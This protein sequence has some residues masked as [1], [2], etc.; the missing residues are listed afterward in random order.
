MSD[1][2][3]S[4][5]NPGL[6]SADESAH[7]RAIVD[8]RRRLETLERSGLESL[9]EL[10]DEIAKLELETVGL[11]AARDDGDAS[12]IGLGTTL[13][14]LRHWRVLCERNQL[15][16][17]AADCVELSTRA[18]RHAAAAWH[19]RV[20]AES[21]TA[22][23][24]ALFQHLLRTRQ[25]LLDIES[26][27]GAASRTERPVEELRNQLRERLKER[28]AEQ[29][30]T[31]A[32]SDEWASLIVDQSATILTAIDELDPERAVVQLELAIDAAQWHLQNVD[33]RR[34]RATSRIHAKLK[35]LRA[36][37]QER[38][39]NA[40]MESLF[41]RRFVGFTERV[42]LFLIVLVIVLMGIEWTVPLSEPTLF[43]FNIVDAGACCI[44]LLEFFTRLCL[45]SER[46]SWF[47]RHFLI[48]LVPSIPIGF[49]SAGLSQADV[50]RA[51]RLGRLLRLSR[52][53]RY[54]RILR[55]VMQA[56][57]V[58]GLMAR[59]IDRLVRG[60]SHILNCNVV[61]HPTPEES[62]H[63]LARMQRED[64][65]LQTL[66]QRVLHAWGTVLTEAEND[67]ERELVSAARLKV[68]SQTCDEKL[69]RFDDGAAVATG[70]R[71]IPAEALLNQMES[72]EPAM[73]E[74][75]LG[76]P[77]TLQLAKAVR[78][79]GAAPFKWLP[80]LR[81][82]V[83][84]NA[85][86]LDDVTAIAESARLSA[87][88]IRGFYDLWFWVA[89]LYGTVTPSQFLDRV[90][91]LLVKSSSR[92]AYRLALFG[93]FLLLIEL[94]FAVAELE[95]LAP[96][97]QFLKNFVGTTVMVVGGIC[98]VILS[99]GWWLQRVAR[100][101]TEF[102]EK[103]VLGQ[104]LLLTDSI[105]AERLDRDAALLFDRV[106]MPDWPR[107][108]MGEASQETLSRADDV[109]SAS[110]VQREP[111]TLDEADW[112]TN[113]VGELAELLRNSM[114]HVQSDLATT[115]FPFLD[116][117]TLMYRDW[118]DGAMF[119]SSDTRATT[120]LLGNTALRQL[121]LTS[122]RITKKH[123]K[124]I[125]VVD[126]ES[127]KS[128]FKGPYLWF[129]FIGQSIAHS[130]ACL[131]VEYN[132][133]A[134]PLH[135]LDHCSDEQKAAYASW[136]GTATTEETDIT[137]PD[138]EEASYVTTAFT[139]LHFLDPD[140]RRE[141]EVESRFGPAVL[142]R[143]KR[144]RALMIRRTFG[145]FPMH[146]RPRGERVVNLFALYEGWIAGG[147]VFLL[148]VFLLLEVF[149]LIGKLIAFVYRAAKEIRN[150]ERRA[151]RIDAAQADFSVALRK[152]NRIRGPVAAECARLRARLDPAWLGT[153]LPG[154]TGTLLQGSDAVTDL[155]FLQL[156]PSLER[157]V[158]AER[159]RAEDDMRLLDHALSEGL[160]AR[161]AEQRGLSPSAFTTRA[162]L[163]AA[164]IA[165]HADLHGVRSRLFARKLLQ[166][167][168]GTTEERPK[169]TDRLS[170]RFRLRSAFRRYWS[171]H[172]TDDVL[173]RRT[174]WRATLKNE[175][176]IQPALHA[177]AEHGDD[178]SSIGEKLLGDVLSHP[179]R[180]TEQLLALRT[181]QSFTVLDVLHYRDQ[182]RELGQY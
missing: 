33:Q 104:F 123:L 84:G 98:I 28:V 92:P 163:R 161:I 55:P 5:E 25:F 69:I 171:A 177:W 66:Q 132:R 176:D 115:E 76:R 140:D 145:T 90:G 119:T 179:G 60:N 30:P 47:R 134:I 21:E 137:R 51:G 20:W 107:P 43:W 67:T 116:R 50:L 14:W 139:A 113:R 166:D 56:V 61:L 136:L 17:P 103:S 71:D 130:C 44:F 12:T 129:Q 29:K 181:I 79:L 11:L 22:D 182:I 78:R 7:H 77:L 58:F 27:E 135:E 72:I 101:A 173:A 24:E 74:P 95:T 172:G 127:Q 65:E 83:P 117:L 1:Q 89:D 32:Q 23:A 158:E 154:E 19:D 155:Q 124:A 143:M 70:V 16:G 97:R 81:G 15:D 160:L 63:Y 73:I 49:L 82:M 52:L 121:M 8:L 151:V 62:A 141:A 114:T 91:G 142:E 13:G 85:S 167:V 39:L 68:L 108:E 168:Y 174:A 128:P 157:D 153:S 80:I 138:E 26:R 48:D 175:N 162:H 149:R 75:M 112:R 106:L 40:R 31:A 102:Y 156:G 105:R 118:L 46:W 3:R 144:D 94:L 169:W 152:I 109:N 59:G 87:R 110:M 180:I 2:E 36:E 88:Y 93:S 122:H 37:L 4:T 147:R 170:P 165:I 100:E 18:L 111:G 150:P 42:V 10:C 125:A 126:L 96:V 131:L 178:V 53:I 9:S 6:V 133:K 164:G 34:C 148:P 57:R 99:V 159:R 146:M 54:V 45:V 35:R 120:Q 86:Q 41:G 64:V 38:R